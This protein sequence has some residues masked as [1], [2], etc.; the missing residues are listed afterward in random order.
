MRI[1]TGGV[2]GLCTGANVTC[3]GNLSVTNGGKLLV[4]GGRTNALASY[5]SLVDVEGDISVA[6]SSWVYPVSHRVNG[7]AVL[8]RA[9]S[10]SIAASGG[11]N[12]DARGWKKD[13]GPGKGGVAVNPAFRGGGG[14]GGKGGWG[15]L[16]T[17]KASPGANYGYSNAPAGPG[18]GG[19][20]PV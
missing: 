14:Y 8:F 11:F 20:G 1:G 13:K 10:V 17:D 16:S 9:R 12:A 15:G 18:S 7:G 6:A 2:L 3:G 5:G 4:F 19:G